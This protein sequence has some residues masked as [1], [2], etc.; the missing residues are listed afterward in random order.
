M[1]LLLEPEDLA[2]PDF[3][4]PLLAE[5]VRRV[6]VRFLALVPVLFDAD[7]LVVPDWLE[8]LWLEVLWPVPDWLV[9]D[10]LLLEPAADDEP[11]PVVLSVD[12]ASPAL[13][14][15]DLTPLSAWSTARSAVFSALSA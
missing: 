9:A 11:V 6:L 8:P 1:L 15:A 14:A 10:W 2:L 7:W 12:T 5:D 13:S 3:V 4:E